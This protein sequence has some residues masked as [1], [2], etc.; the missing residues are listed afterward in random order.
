MELRLLFASNPFI[1][2]HPQQ[3]FSSFLLLTH[4]LTVSLESAIRVL[5]LQAILI[6]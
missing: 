3:K 6:A 5:A 2:I 4:L 1:I